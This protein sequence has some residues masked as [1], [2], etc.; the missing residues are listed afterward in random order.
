MRLATFESDNTWRP[1][2]LVGETIVDAER[3]AQYA[4][5]ADSRDDALRTSFASNRRIIQCAPE[6]LQQLA[7]AAHTLTSEGKGIA[8]SK[9]RLG[10]QNHD[11]EKLVAGSNRFCPSCM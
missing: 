9:T 1:G 11:P 5:L 6:E 3:A 2:V 10:P 4:A 7:S 8:L